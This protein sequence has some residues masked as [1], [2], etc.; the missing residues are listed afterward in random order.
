MELAD[1]VA[2]EVM[3]PVPVPLLVAVPVGVPVGVGGGVPLLDSDVLAVFEGEAPAVREAVGVADSV[4]LKDT[5]VLGEAGGV[6][7]PV[8]VGL[9]EGVP[10]GVG[11]G[12]RLLDS[13]VLPVLEAEAPEESEGVGDTV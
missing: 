1:R 3:D 7:V 9:P 8:D 11:G 10:V 5:V 13:E 12:V 4:E 6:P 2:L